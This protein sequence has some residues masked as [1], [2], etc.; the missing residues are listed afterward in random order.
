[1][2]F[3]F[4]THPGMGHFHPLVP[5]A[6][7]LEQRGHEVSFAVSASFRAV[8]EDAGFAVFPAGLDWLQSDLG[9]A[10]PETR[11][12]SVG[13]LDDYIVLRVMWDAAVGPMVHDVTRI[14]SEWHADAIVR[15][16]T[17][18]GGCLA[19]EALGIPHAA[20]TILGFHLQPKDVVETGRK[21]LVDLRVEYGLPPDP[22]LHM[23]Y[24]HLLLVTLPRSWVGDLSA[25]PQH[26]E[27]L[28]PMA[29][30]Q[31][32]PGR[33]PDWI[34]E[35]PDRPTIYASLGTVYNRV[36]APLLRTIRDALADEPVN[37]IMLFGNEEDRRTFGPS[38]PNVYLRPFVP[39]TLLMAVCNLVITHGGINTVM[40]S[41]AEGV[42]L[43][44]LPVGGDQPV[45]A[46]RIKDLGLGQVIL[47][48]RPRHSFAGLCVD[49]DSVGPEDIRAA[50]RSVMADSNYRVRALAFQ[51]EL[52][53]LPGVE[54]A[55]GAL[56]WL[57][58]QSWRSRTSSMP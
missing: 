21:R 52:A 38:P 12:L 47:G 6:G 29:L 15:D 31:A 18:A 41:L 33:A 35:L 20:Q 39:Q 1:M 11:S 5:I 45:V 50:V 28:R 10:F 24:R 43:V 25:L 49:P 48:S 26:C 13:D 53:Q 22:D 44:V 9:R 3:L 32:D 27:W 40:T 7:A 2:R 23:L 54:A 34:G 58:Q 36:A 14:A 30:N 42:P 19:A 8:V 46:Q 17:E 4:T 57:V 37:V 55:V 16:N 56:E 51:A